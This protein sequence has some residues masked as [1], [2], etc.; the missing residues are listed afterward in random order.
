M[1]TWSTLRSE[2]QSII[3][4]Y[5]SLSHHVS[6]FTLWGAPLIPRTRAWPRLALM[7]EADASSDDRGDLDVL[8]YA[9]DTTR[10]ERRWLCEWLFLSRNAAVVCDARTG[11]VFLP[12]QAARLEKPV[13]RADDCACPRDSH[14]INT[15]YVSGGATFGIYITRLKYQTIFVDK[16]S[17]ATQAN[18]CIS[19]RILL[20]LEDNKCQFFTTQR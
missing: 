1:T 14:H 10:N 2:I 19:R 9:D 5:T 16:F 17:Y 18:F 13:S 12:G 4:L 8:Y 7:I 6:L 20:A 11:R 3:L 15:V